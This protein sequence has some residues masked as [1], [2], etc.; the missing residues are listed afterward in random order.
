MEF[1]I[2]V[3]TVI[4]QDGKILLVQEAKEKNFQKWNI[5]GGSMELTE[6][7]WEGAKREVQEETFLD[8]EI[9]SLLGVYNSIGNNHSIRFVF[10]GKI[11]SGTAGAGD[12]I[13]AVKW[14]DPAEL[15]NL[16]PAHYINPLVFE[17][18]AKDYIDG[19]RYPVETVREMGKHNK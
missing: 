12:N 19:V 6:K 14:V 7:A 8:V 16:D 13:L 3:S 11:V 1:K 5:P 2:Y 17:A 10:V 18:L 4:E 9:T 15:V